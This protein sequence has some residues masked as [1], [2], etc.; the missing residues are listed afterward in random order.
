MTQTPDERDQQTA[1]EDGQRPP[2]SETERRARRDELACEVV[3]SRP[4]LLDR[5]RDA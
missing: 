2:L 1:P 4:Q 5:L 3:D